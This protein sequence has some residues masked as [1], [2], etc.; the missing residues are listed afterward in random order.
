MSQLSATPRA[1]VVLSDPR[2]SRAAPRESDAVSFL[3]SN[4][5]RYASLN[6]P[7]K[8]FIGYLIA[9]RARRDFESRPPPQRRKDVATCERIEQ[10]RKL[11]ALRTHEH[12]LSP[13]AKGGSSRG[14]SRRFVDRKQPAID[15]P[16]ACPAACPAAVVPSCVY[17]PEL[18]DDFPDCDRTSLPLES[19]SR[20]NGRDFF[21][22]RL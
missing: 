13:P 10:R 17:T 21:K 2:R 4:E 7:W 19:A 16:A 14:G 9:V 11:A 8:A 3:N 1:V 22:L 12:F 6:F 15:P 20:D 5:P 18:G